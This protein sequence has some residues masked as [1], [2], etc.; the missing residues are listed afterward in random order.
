MVEPN[1][2]INSEISNLE[3]RL[4]TQSD[5]LSFQEGVMFM[6]TRMILE[7]MMSAVHTADFGERQKML[8][9]ARSLYD[10]AEIVAKKYGQVNLAQN[11]F[12]CYEYIKNIVGELQ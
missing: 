11:H 3:A 5:L 6:Q 12:D 4:K 1:S 9:Q 7:S 2:D 10:G 8:S